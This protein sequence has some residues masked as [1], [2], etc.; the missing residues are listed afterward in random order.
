MRGE[1][2]KLI[3]DKVKQVQAEL[4]AALADKSVTIGEITGLVVTTVG[5]LTEI[6]KELPATWREKRDAVNTLARRLYD[7][8]IAQKDIDLIPGRGENPDGLPE[9]WE[10]AADDFLRGTIEPAIALCFK[11]LPKDKNESPSFGPVA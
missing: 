3:G 7:E 2:Y 1:L 10:G 4:R 11:V 9:G 8:E 6:V 5:G